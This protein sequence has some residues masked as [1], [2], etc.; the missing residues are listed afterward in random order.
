MADFT[1]G[2]DLSAR[3]YHEAVRPALD[4]LLPGVPHAAALIGDGSE[5]HGFDSIRSTDHAWG[6]HVLLFLSTD[7]L[8]SSPALLERDLASRLPETFQGYSTH[9]HQGDPTSPNG[10]YRM[11]TLIRGVE[12]HEPGAWVRSYL[13]IDPRS[14]PSPSNWLALPWTLLRGVTGGVVHHDG[15]GDITAIRSA[16]SW[17]PNDLWRYLVACQWQRINQEEPFVGRTAEAGDDIG[18]RLIANRQI[19]EV[20]HLCFLLT[21]RYPPYSKWLGTAFQRLGCA[22]ALLPHMLDASS[23]QN[24]ETRERA[25]THMYTAVAQLHNDSGMTAPLSV[26]IEQFHDRPYKVLNSYRF[27]EAT[28]ATIADPSIRR[29]PLYGCISQCVDSTDVLSTRLG[30]S[31]FA[32]VLGRQQ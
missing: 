15:F 19:R 14:T 12:I 28:R 9:F 32:D 30:A 4:R 24:Y 2:L 23:A 18:S 20:M 27:V 8:E 17:Y 21:K 7:T 22:P 29:L 5:V 16:V 10:P 26:A 11:G 31:P 13:G 3:Y 25:L 6:P 1:T